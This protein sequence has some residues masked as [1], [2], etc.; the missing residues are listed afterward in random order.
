MTGHDL[1]PFLHRAK[2]HGDTQA[3]VEMI[4]Y[5][6]HIG[7]CC[8]LEND[9]LVFRLPFQSSLVGNPALEALHGGVLETVAALTLVWRLECAAM[10]KT[11][12]NSVDYLRSA[13]REDIFGAGEVTRLGRRV[14]S[15]SVSA[16]GRDRGRPL[17]T[18]RL[19]YLVSKDKAA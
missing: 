5:A 2:R 17:A 6:G 16:W 19:H 14:A 9:E 8:A 18:A 4:P 1:T 13:R 7:V 12:T 10:P 11:I 15:V 3:L